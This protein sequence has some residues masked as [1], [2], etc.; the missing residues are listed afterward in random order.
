MIWITRHADGKRET[1]LPSRP[2]PSRQ[3]RRRRGRGSTAPPDGPAR[4]PRPTGRAPPSKTNGANP[5]GRRGI[6]VPPGGKDGPVVP[7][8]VLAAAAELL[9]TPGSAGYLFRPNC[10]SRGTNTVTNFLS[11]TKPNSANTVLHCSKDGALTART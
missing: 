7:E 4:R 10:H 2:V 9:E 1:L 6:S 11:R 8:T 3:R 5:F